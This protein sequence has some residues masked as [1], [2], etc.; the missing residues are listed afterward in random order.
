ML[1]KTASAAAIVTLAEADLVGSAMLVAFMFTV[2]GEGIL[3]GVTYKPVA[4]IVPH[5]AP[6]QPEPLTLQMTAV[7]EVPAMLPANC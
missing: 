3:A 2:A 1:T 5:A 4:E 7:L 6:L